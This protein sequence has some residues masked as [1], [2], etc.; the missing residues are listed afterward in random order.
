[1]ARSV[2]YSD[3]RTPDVSAQCEFDSDTL[4]QIDVAKLL[5]QKYPEVSVTNFTSVCR[6][7]TA[8]CYRRLLGR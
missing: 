7:L 3:T 1:M 2:R 5:I 8:R 6:M 4:E